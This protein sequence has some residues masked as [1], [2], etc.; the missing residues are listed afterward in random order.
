MFFKGKFYPEKLIICEHYSDEYDISAVWF[1]CINSMT[2]DN[3][4]FPVVYPARIKTTFIDSVNEGDIDG[5]ISGVD[6][7]CV[8]VISTA[9]GFGIVNDK[10]EARLYKGGKF[11]NAFIGRSTTEIIQQ[12][13]LF[14][15]EDVSTFS[16]MERIKIMTEVEEAFA[17]KTVI[18]VN[19][20]KECTVRDDLAAS[21]LAHK[22]LQD[23]VSICNKYAFWCDVLYVIKK[24]SGENMFEIRVHDPV[25]KN[26][27]S[28][29]FFEA[30]K[31]ADYRKISERV[32]HSVDELCEYITESI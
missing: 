22:D 32:C 7:G 3:G 27:D 30:I 12:A 20:Q 17:D 26:R 13:F 18:F 15:I 23:T 11:I 1:T 25:E 14:N 6:D 31:S 24:A 16:D 4:K 21:L 10:M 19:S 8:L 5:V 29:T 2:F 28:K 9:K